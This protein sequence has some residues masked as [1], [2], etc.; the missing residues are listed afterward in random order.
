MCKTKTFHVFFTWLLM[1]LLLAACTGQEVYLETFDVQG[2]WSAGN[3]GDAVGEVKEG[4][5]DLFVQADDIIIWTTAVQSFSDG[6]YEV[7]ATPVEGTVNNG[8]GLMFRVN[9]DTDDF[10]LFKVS[11]D[12][13]VWIG[14]CKAGCTEETPLV[15]EW[16]FESTAVKQGNNVTNQLKVR[17]EGANMI[18][19][20]NDVEVGRFTDPTLRSGDIGLLVQTLGQGGVRVRFDNFQ[21]SPLEK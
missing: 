17:A 1:V 18:F 13:F 19:Y 6:V 8:Y 15:T 3:D 14:L 16:W 10:Y 5:Y 7:Q 11:G 9:N 2:S 20:V 12:G 4:V 21:V